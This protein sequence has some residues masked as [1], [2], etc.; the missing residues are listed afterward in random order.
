MIFGGQ[1][2]L[3]IVIFDFTKTVVRSLYVYEPSERSYE[4][5]LFLPILHKNICT[6]STQK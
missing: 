4:I 1:N 6:P 3:F 5:F 2:H